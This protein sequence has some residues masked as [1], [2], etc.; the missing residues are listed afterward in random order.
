M[1]NV[2]FGD[3]AVTVDAHLLA[4]G[5]VKPIAFT[6]RERRWQVSG[7]GRQWDEADGRHV[8]VTTSDGGRFELCLRSDQNRWQLVRA[9]EQSLLA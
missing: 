7:L 1:N 8:L 4:N 6:W 5:K 9:W 3:E 2:W